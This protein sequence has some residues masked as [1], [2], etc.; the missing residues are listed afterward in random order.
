[1]PS[2][3][4]DEEFLTY[5]SMG[6]VGVRRVIEDLKQQGRSPLLLERGSSDFKLWKR[7]RIKGWRVPDI[8]CV[9]TGRRIESRAK[10]SFEISGSHSTNNAERLGFWAVRY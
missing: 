6:A 9:D 7:L 8:L 3:K 5:I 2:F 1:M 10:A 4:S